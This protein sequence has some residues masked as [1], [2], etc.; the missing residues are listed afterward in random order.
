MSSGVSRASSAQ[1]TQTSGQVQTDRPRDPEAAGKFRDSMQ[2]SKS[3]GSD[4]VRDRGDQSS[5]LDDSM[6]GQSEVRQQYRDQGRVDSD[7]G[8]GGRGQ[9]GQSDDRGGGRDSQGQPQTRLHDPRMGVPKGPQAPAHPPG[10]QGL[11]SKDAMMHQTPPGLSRGTMPSA[12]LPKHP[13]GTVRGTSPFGGKQLG[14][15]LGQHQ[16]PTLKQTRTLG[17]R[18]M[19]THHLQTEARVRDPRVRGSLVLLEGSPKHAGR[20]LRTPPPS[21]G[22]PLVGTGE[23]K[24]VLDKMPE[25]VVSGHSGAGARGDRLEDGMFTEREPVDST[26]EVREREFKP[27]EVVAKPQIEFQPRV[28]ESQKV[29]QTQKMTSVEIAEIVRKVEQMV[30]N[31]RLQTNVQGDKQMSLTISDG[32]LKGVEVKVSINPAGKVQAEFKAENVDAR[33]TLSQ[34]IKELEKSLEAKGLEVNKLEIGSDAAGRR[35]FASQKEQQQKHEAAQAALD[36][37][38]STGGKSARD[39]RMGGPK[40]AAARPAS[41]APGAVPTG[42]AVPTG[43]GPET[44]NYVA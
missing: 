19:P 20:A 4:G 35:D 44:S 28:V 27:T 25:L 39:P 24:G 31:V 15:I 23:K 13:L 41:G 30:S 16:K 18:G 10:H 40:P 17:S 5:R 22:A 2:S 6:R 36:G 34:N 7:G 42:T 43:E 8:R 26:K 33:N 32:R 37:M 21:A 9:G 38:D 11:H 14:S 29:Q 12:T 3:D 1:P